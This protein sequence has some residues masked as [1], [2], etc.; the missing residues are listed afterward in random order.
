MS[1]KRGFT[2]IELLVVIAIIG[3]L[4]SVVLASLNS[5]RRKGR[6]A[7]RV[8]DIKQLQL[9]LELYYDANG[10]YPTGLTTATLVTPGY[11]SVIPK[12]PSSNLDYAYVGLQGSASSAATCSS[13]HL[14]T[15]LENNVTTTG[16]LA[17]DAD[18]AVGGSFGATSDGAVCTGSAWVG[19]AD[20]AAASSDF[21][22]T[23]PVYDVRP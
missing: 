21:A 14:G 15:K 18:A 9:A 11:M 4:S 1:Y 5:A 6:D 10:Q 2:L 3:I 16:P 23:D 7:R 20:I 8:A 19:N 17:G 22:G 12:D 13:Y